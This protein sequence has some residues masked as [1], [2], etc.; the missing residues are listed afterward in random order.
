M[1]REV[2]L[3]VGA[4]KSGTTYLQSVLF[5]RQAELAEAGVLVPGARWADQVRG[6]RA[7]I[8]HRGAG[9]VDAEWA[10]L[11]EQAGAWPGTAV[12]SMEFLAALRPEQVRL[13]VDSFEGSDVHVVV[14]LRDLNRSLAAMW[15]ETV[16]NGRSWTWADYLAGVEHARRPEGPVTE[17]GRTFWRQ[18]DAVAIVGRWA[19]AAGR[20]TV[21]TVPP[22]GA[23]P[24]VLL[25]RFAE[26]IGFDAASIG[27]VRSN[28]SIGA[29][30]AEVLRRVNELLSARGVA[31]KR[32]M[33][34]RKKE[35]G[36]QVLS[37]RS[38]EEPR[39]GLPVAPWLSEQS[40]AMVAAL[41]AMPE[42]RLVGDWADLTPVDV[43]GVDPGGVAEAELL[44]AA[45]AGRTGL[46]AR[47]RQ[48]HPADRL[49]T[50]AEPPQDLDAAVAALADLVECA[51]RLDEER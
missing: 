36:K 33:R 28:P 40:A 49:P 50:P 19:A 35:L 18:Q 37:G 26:T 14:S 7:V 4:M 27:D 15:Q 20:T 34:V 13:V 17:A 21:V 51:I 42:V 1:A 45:V 29:A 44:A 25:D 32:G 9:P 47:L 12:I 39:I 5:S 46:V 3:H 30:S 10:S 2:V 8:R 22:P 48:R 23:P 24:E 41:A 11:V 38:R 31:F 16:Q 6:V 43:P